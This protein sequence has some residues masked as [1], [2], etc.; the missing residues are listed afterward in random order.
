MYYTPKEEKNF[1]WVDSVKDLLNIR[2]KNLTEYIDNPL[3]ALSYIAEQT[4]LTLNFDEELNISNTGISLS[5]IK[6]F[7]KNKKF[8]YS[9]WYEANKSVINM[10]THDI[11][12][13]IKILQLDIERFKNEELKPWFFSCYYSNNK[14]GSQLCKTC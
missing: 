13:I 9:R 11:D 6:L 8:Y 14:N 10:T 1:D 7:F 2:N 12:T 3:G 4:G 5:H